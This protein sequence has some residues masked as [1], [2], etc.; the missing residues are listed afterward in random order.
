VLLKRPRSSPSISLLEHQS[1]FSFS[2]IWLH[3]TSACYAVDSSCNAVDLCLAQIS[4]DCCEYSS[5]FYSLRQRNF[6]SSTNKNGQ[7]LL[8]SSP[9]FSSFTIAF[10][11]Y[12]TLH[13]LCSGN[14]SLNNVTIRLYVKTNHSCQLKSTNNKFSLRERKN[15]EYLLHCNRI[16]WVKIELWSFRTRSW[17]SNTQLYSIL[18][19]LIYLFSAILTF[20]CFTRCMYLHEY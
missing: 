2:P 8:H 18:L 15:D 7:R 3:T 6:R 9:A 16:L 20:K 12:S 19:F 5:W 14:S 4:A 1:S 13:A 10:P 17:S 11:R